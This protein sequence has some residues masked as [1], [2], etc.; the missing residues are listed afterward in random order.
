[1]KKNFFK[2]YLFS[3]LA[4]ASASLILSACDKNNDDDNNDNNKSY[5]ISGNASGSQ[6]TPAVTTS[7]TGTLTGTYNARTNTLTYN[8]SWNG[9]S[10]VASAAHFHGP[11]TAGVAADVLVPI[12]ITTNGITGNATG[13]VTIVDSVENALLDGKVYYNVHTAAHPLGE[14]RGQV[15][16]TAN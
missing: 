6:E 12:T 2:R 14:I 7:A 3:A 4:I 16:A 15:T 11:A 10:G 1:M 8:I 9:L 5:T 13:T